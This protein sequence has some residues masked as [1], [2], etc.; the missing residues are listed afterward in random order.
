MCLSFF[1]ANAERKEATFIRREINQQAGTIIELYVLA[2]YLF[3]NLTSCYGMESFDVVPPQ[4]PLTAETAVS[5]VCHRLRCSRYF[6]EFV[7]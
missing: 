1:Q 5:L 7:A 4:R 2:I 3:Y 6:H